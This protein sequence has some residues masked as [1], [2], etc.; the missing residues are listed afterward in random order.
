M[1]DTMS[2]ASQTPPPKV[3][4]VIP[5]YNDGNYVGRAIES[6]LAQTLKE[7]QVI[8]V[9]DGS[10][11]GTPEVLRRYEGR[12]K[13]IR[14]ENKGLSAARNAGIAASSGEYVSFLDSD[15]TIMP[16]KSELLAAFLDQRPE[17]GL[18]FGATQRVD[19]TGQ[20]VVAPYPASLPDD[21]MVSL[22]FGPP[23]PPIAPLLRR[24]WLDRVGGFDERLRA[25]E[26]W[27]CWCRLYVAGCKFSPIDDQSEL[28]AVLIRPGSLSRDPEL[29]HRHRMLALDRY[30]SALGPRCPKWLEPSAR[31]SVWLVT[32]ADRLR[33][34]QHEAAKH[35][36]AKALQI[37]ADVFTRQGSWRDVLRH[38]DPVFPIR[39]PKRLTSYRD[40][41]RSLRSILRD[42]AVSGI[43]EH[44]EEWVARQLSSLAFALSKSAFPI[45]MSWQARWW[46]AKSF[47]IFFNRSLLRDQ[48]P[49]ILKILM[50][51][52]VSE[53]TSRILR[54]L[55]RGSDRA[56]ITTSEKS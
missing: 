39:H 11:D 29:M 18:C 33:L 32:G 5:V 35:A 9:D 56:E 27:D 22:A 40:T 8:V 23:F 3:S 49:T 2:R 30:F 52:S 13:V 51:R 34:S 46:L 28:G 1:T 17:V 7:V 37:D 26:D 16:K 31:S 48:R 45:G 42:L 38:L 36:W 15:D 10:T 25:C 20:Q 12:I 47:V 44:Q 41:Y 50:G 4:I 53:F 24:E 54:F 21:L 6:A 43:R 14:Q 55:G 19:G